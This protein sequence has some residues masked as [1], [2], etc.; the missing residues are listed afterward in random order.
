MFQLIEIYKSKIHFQP[1]PLFDIALL[2]SQWPQWPPYLLHSFLAASLTFTDTSFHENMKSF[3]TDRFINLAR[4]MAV[5]LAAEGIP[6]LPVLQSLCLLTICDIAG[7]PLGQPNFFIL[8]RYN[9][10]FLVISARNEPRVSMNICIATNLA[11][12]ML[13][14][15]KN[16]DQKSPA[17]KEEEV[18]CYWTVSILES[19]LTQGKRTLYLERPSIVN[20]PNVSIPKVPPAI[21][22]TESLHSD[23][24]SAVDTPQNNWNI[25]V[26]CLH[27]LSIWGKIIQ[28]TMQGQ[29]GQSEDAWLASSAYSDIE[30]EFY[31]FETNLAQIH[32]FKNVDFSSKSLDE[33]SQYREYWSTWLLLQTTF[34]TGHALLNHPFVHVLRHDRPKARP[35]T[36]K[37]PSFIQRTIDQALLHSGW[38]SR[39]I[40]MADDIGLQVTDPVI[41]HQVIVTATVHWIFSFASDT[42]I[43]ERALSQLDQCQK[44]VHNIANHW[45]QFAAKV[46]SFQDYI[47]VFILTANYLRLSRLINC[48]SLRDRQMASWDSWG[49]QHLFHCLYG[50]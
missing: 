40:C 3:S 18:R 16:Q 8:Y 37:P 20:L 26:Y 1:F 34:H 41:C 13:H 6:S 19:V 48:T 31:R 25:F 43:A 15:S 11:K 38:T 39:L 27:L 9:S 14:D 7:R 21:H 28:Y 30:I 47:A 17:L 36:F 44:F 22:T 45:P 42:S 12:S 29:C 4:M 23:N 46:S 35:D 24:S 10:H 2:P 32:R 33:I 50:D 5:P 49:Y